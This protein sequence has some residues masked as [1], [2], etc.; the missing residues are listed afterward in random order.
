MYPARGP[1]GR[2]LNA[3]TASPPR[4][5]A[6]AATPH[7][8]IFSSGPPGTSLPACAGRHVVR[9]NKPIGLGRPV[10]PRREAQSCT[11]TRT[12]SKGHHVLP[13]RPPSSSVREKAL[14]DIAKSGRQQGRSRHCFNERFPYSNTAFPHSNRTL[15]HRRPHHFCEV[16]QHH[17][18]A[19]TETRTSAAPAVHVKASRLAVNLVMQEFHGRGS[20]ASCSASCFAPSA[21]PGARRRRWAP[22]ASRIIASRGSIDRYGDRGGARSRHPGRPVPCTACL[23]RPPT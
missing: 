18:A 19:L 11:A 7:P 15:P 2:T 9:T 23:S 1:S 12:A 13:R 8:R 4:P 21:L 16:P 20:H 3:G 14:L 17:A 10:D 6:R 22:D 5:A